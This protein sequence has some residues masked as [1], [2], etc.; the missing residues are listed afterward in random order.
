MQLIHVILV[1]VCAFIKNKRNRWVIWVPSV[2]PII[3]A[4]IAIRVWSVLNN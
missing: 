4:L 1:L 3:G 2:G